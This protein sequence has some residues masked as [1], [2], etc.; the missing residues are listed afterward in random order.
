MSTINYPE[1][2]ST[3][4]GMQQAR[5]SND[6]KPRR[7]ARCG[8]DLPDRSNASH[9]RACQQDMQLIRNVMQAHH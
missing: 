1:H 8:S 5:E 9:C 3:F 7:C 4:M 2:N 6:R